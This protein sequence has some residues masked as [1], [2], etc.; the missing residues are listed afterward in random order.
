VA[1][2]RRSAQSRTKREHEERILMI[3]RSFAQG[4][5]RIR[6]GDRYDLGAD[7]RARLRLLQLGTP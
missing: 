4:C 1:S 3:R 6:R 7:H 5:V 2:L